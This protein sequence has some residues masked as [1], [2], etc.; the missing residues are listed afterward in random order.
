MEFSALTFLLALAAGVLSTL[1]PCVLPLIPVL[2]WAALLAHRL[3]P[4]ALAG[5]LALSYTVVGMLLASVGSVAG[6]DQGSLRV[7]GAAVLLLFGV[8]L[9][10]PAL[11]TAFASATSRLSNIGQICLERLAPQALGGQFLISIVLG[12]VWSPC[13]GPTLGGAIMLASQREHFIEAGVVMLLFGV[14]AATPLLVL[15]SLS[16]AALQRVRG[17]LLVAGHHGKIALGMVF[18]VLGV[19][20]LT[21]SDQTLEAWLLEQAPPWLLELTVSL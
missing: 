2:A 5:G 13:V 16:R 17:G 1:A 11:Q 7:A 12:L 9:L 15:G 8:I 10:V 4:F 6:L 3:G 19:L 21:G 14:G 20:M 18:V